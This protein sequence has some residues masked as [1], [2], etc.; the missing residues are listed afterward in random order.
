M[1]DDTPLLTI[2]NG[3]T[4]PPI[5][6]PPLWIFNTPLLAPK[7]AYSRHPKVLKLCQAPQNNDQLELHHFVPVAFL[8]TFDALCLFR[9]K[10]H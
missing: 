1:F 4:Y 6:Q 3:Y 8:S 7:T 2:K 10:T 5:L 9:K